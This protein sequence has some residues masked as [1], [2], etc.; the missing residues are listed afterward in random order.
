M[1][2]AL[3]NEAARRNT[4]AFFAAGFRYVLVHHT[5]FESPEKL[6]RTLDVVRAHRPT[7]ERTLGTITVFVFETEGA[8]GQGRKGAK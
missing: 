3:S 2:E 1:P 8:E 6:A 7:G 5:R 4:E